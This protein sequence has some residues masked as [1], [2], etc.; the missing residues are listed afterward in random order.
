MA[1]AG[2]SATAILLHISAGDCQATL[3]GAEAVGD[4]LEIMQRF[5]FSL[6]RL[7]VA[8]TLFA[9][10]SVCLGHG[11]PIALW[12]V[13][14]ALGTLLKNPEAGFWIAVLLTPFVLWLY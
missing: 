4:I 7:L 10:A 14:I 9:V 13:G 12:I 6:T 3:F 5:Q 2:R 8:M 1:D 11:W